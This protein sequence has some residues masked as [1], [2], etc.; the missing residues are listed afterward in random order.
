MVASGTK[1]GYRFDL[2]TLNKSPPLP[3]NN[4]PT[5]PVTMRPTNLKINS[6]SSFFSSPY[7]SSYPAGQLSPIPSEGRD[8]APPSSQ[9]DS[10]TPLLPPTPSMAEKGRESFPFPSDSRGLWTRIRLATSGSYRSTAKRVLG[11][12]LLAGILL[13]IGRQAGDVSVTLHFPPKEHVD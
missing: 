4:P 6:S 13:M 10:T 2:K 8:S 9:H 11:F 1:P 3:P 5:V 12:I 7:R